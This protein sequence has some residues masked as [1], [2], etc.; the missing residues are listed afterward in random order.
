M[1]PFIYR[2]ERK[3][4][5][6]RQ[7]E[8]T[9]RQEMHLLMSERDRILGELDQLQ[10][11]I[12]CLEELIRSY[13]GNWLIPEAGLCKE[14]LPILR[15][16]FYH[17]TDELLLAEGRVEKARQ[18]VME[19]KRETKTYEKLRENDWQDY[20]YESNREEQKV[21]DELAMAAEIRN[22]R[23]KGTGS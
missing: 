9:V 5:L 1:K 22:V 7:E 18:K 11:R 3:L 6:V 2:F 17:K 16:H 10:S 4:G 21:I 12:H 14:Y 23:R 8:Q 20:R 19:K 15:E 13:D